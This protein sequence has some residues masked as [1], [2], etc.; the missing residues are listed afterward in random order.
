MQ[1]VYYMPR[2][3]YRRGHEN[4]EYA[5]G[6]HVLVFGYIDLVAGGDKHFFSKA[7]AEDG[8]PSVENSEE[9]AFHGFRG[10]CNNKKI[11]SYGVYEIKRIE[12]WSDDCVKI[13]LGRKDF[14]LRED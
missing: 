4:G 7:F 5:V 8:Y 9:K 6:D 10:T 13:T 11:Y 2:E 1:Y 12:A 14:R 3:V